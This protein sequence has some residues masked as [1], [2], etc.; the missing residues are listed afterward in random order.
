MI[1]RTSE[2][3]DEWAVRANEP[4]D[5]QVAQ[6]LR[7]DY[8]LDWT[9]VRRTAISQQQ[10]FVTPGKIV[11]IGSHCRP[12]FKARKIVSFLLY[13][14]LHRAKMNHADRNGASLWAKY[15]NMK[16][17]KKYGNFVQNRPFPTKWEGERDMQI[18]IYTQIHV[19]NSHVCVV[20]AGLLHARIWRI[21][22][23]V[24]SSFEFRLWNRK[25][26]ISQRFLDAFSHLYKMVCLSVRRSVYRSVALELKTCK[27]AV[28][29]QNWVR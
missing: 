22:P 6:Y 2:Q 20:N 24:I 27:S 3:I 15:K 16:R 5:K 19:C 14:L 10:N 13:L 28:F 18:C 1:E 17:E 29:D 12:F 11:I 21:T 4:A 8:W 26:E 25:A 7:P 23:R 9:T